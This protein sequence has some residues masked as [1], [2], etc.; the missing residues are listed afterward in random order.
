MDDFTARSNDVLPKSPVGQ[1]ISYARAQWDDLRACTRYGDP[2]I[3]NNVSER[4]LHAQAI[5]LKN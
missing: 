1:A 3:D 4:L 5:G 2:S